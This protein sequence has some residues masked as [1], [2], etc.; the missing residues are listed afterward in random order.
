MYTHMQR[1]RTFTGGDHVEV[2]GKITWKFYRMRRDFRRINPDCFSL[3]FGGKE[4]H[5][6]GMDFSHLRNP[7]I[8]GKKGKPQNNKEFLAK[9]ENKENKKKTRK[10]RSGKSQSLAMEIRTFESRCF[11]VFH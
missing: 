5:Q 11:F 1:L 9:E 2:V 10:G 4:N 3:L 6:K 8:A 7:E